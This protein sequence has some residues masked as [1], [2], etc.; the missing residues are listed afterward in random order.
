M[1]TSAFLLAILMTGC[2]AHAD[3]TPPLPPTDAERF[4]TQAIGSWSSRAQ[5]A[6]PDFDWVESE[7]VILKSDSTTGVWLYQENA[8]LGAAPADTPKADAKEKPYFQVIIQLRDLGQGRVHT[9]TYRLETP[10][11]KAAAK[12]TLREG[13][14][15]DLSLIGGVACMGSMTEIARGYWRGETECPNGYKGGVKVDSQSLRTPD[16]YVNWDRGFDA[17]GKQVW[18]PA[19]GG[20]VFNRKGS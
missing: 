15:F 16:T 4:A 10:E 14:A 9:T 20:Y 11:A 19:E 12:R 6:S 17:N 2:A 7:M 18:G 8:I 5:S 13:V 1:K 3:V